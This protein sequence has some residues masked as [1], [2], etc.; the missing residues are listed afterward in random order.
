M[1]RRYEYALP[2]VHWIREADREL[3][4]L[5]TDALRARAVAAEKW[6][7]VGGDPSDVDA[8]AAKAAEIEAF[9][10]LQLAVDALAAKAAKRD[11]VK[12]LDWADD[13]DDDNED[14]YDTCKYIEQ[15][16]RELIGKFGKAGA[17]VGF[18]WHRVAPLLQDDLGAG[19]HIITLPREWCKP[20]TSDDERCIYMYLVTTGYH[21]R[22]PLIVNAWL[23]DLTREKLARV[24]KDDDCLP[25][26]TPLLP[27]VM[28]DVL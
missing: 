5:H 8:L 1:P 24:L 16:T 22:H 6:Y 15:V 25:I 13:D 3:S 4:T 18:P 11:V 12:V 21:Y 7:A 14:G 27:D 26:L 28:D 10:V 9:R 19:L 20:S 23:P 2:V 17:L